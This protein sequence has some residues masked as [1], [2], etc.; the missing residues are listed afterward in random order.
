MDWR[1]GSSE[2]P[3]PQTITTKEMKKLKRT[4]ITLK[5]KQTKQYFFIPSRVLHSKMN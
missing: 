5:N 4:Y 2:A 3:V 1:F